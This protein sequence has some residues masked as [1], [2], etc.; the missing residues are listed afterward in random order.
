MKKLVKQGAVMGI[1][2]LKRKIFPFSIFWNKNGRQH[3]ILPAECVLVLLAA[4]LAT[5]AAQFLR[6]FTL[7]LGKKKR[8]SALRQAVWVSVYLVILFW[9]LLFLY[10]SSVSGGSWLGR[11]RG[12]AQ[13]VE[14]ALSAAEEQPLAFHKGERRRSGTGRLVTSSAWNIH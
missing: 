13:S 12:N 10:V 6:H 2:D 7:L 5:A 4:V 14:K 8:P 3:L 1:G 11:D 9:T